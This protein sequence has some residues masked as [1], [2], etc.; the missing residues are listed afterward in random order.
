MA[1]AVGVE[2]NAAAAS[3][4]RKSGVT[5]CNPSAFYFPEASGNIATCV[6]DLKIQYLYKMPLYRLQKF[7]DIQLIDLEL[8]SGK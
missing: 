6:R 1:R 5:V 4:A 8:T 7:K 2:R 3:S